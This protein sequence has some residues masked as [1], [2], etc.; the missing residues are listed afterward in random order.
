MANPRQQFESDVNPQ[1]RCSNCQTV[2]EVSRELLSSSDTRVRCGEC[3]SIFDALIELRQDAD[4]LRD[5]ATST[6]VSI[7]TNRS[8]S[9]LPDGEA[10][11]RA[12]MAN[13]TGALDVTYSDF[14]LFSGDADLP[15]IAYFDQTRDAPEFDF[16]A[17]ELGT[18]ET[19]SDTLFVHDVTIDADSTRLKTTAPGVPASEPADFAEIGFVA[20]E[21]P[22]EPLIF[23]YRDKEE[24]APPAIDKETALP[25]TSDAATA[26]NIP[27]KRDRKRLSARFGK[28]RAPA[29]SVTLDV[30]ASPAVAVSTPE[31]EALPDEVN[32]SFDGNVASSKPSNGGKVW[33]YRAA[34]LVLLCLLMGALY[35]YRERPRLY[36]IPVVHTAMSGVCSLFGCTIPAP[37]DVASIAMVKRNVYAHPNAPDSLKVDV[38][39]RNDAKFA[40]RFP[41]IVMRLS[42]R[43]G[44]TVTVKEFVPGDYYPGW[45]AGDTI[46]KNQQLDI[47]LDVNDPGK[48]AHSFE[49]SFREL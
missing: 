19:F 43:L 36:N 38:S 9:T 31:A 25:A 22:R 8:A 23:N 27:I 28:S 42:N 17:V 1:T 14:D 45:R 48:S 5:E 34:M 29:S 39:F 20:D 7:N 4:I 16:D 3:L 37:V 15:E 10:A 46:E 6:T 33:G 30:P 12:G 40:Q 49:F 26:H 47:N 21:N 44:R 24:E 18:D 41:V 35:L 2:F 32:A 13:N 11:V